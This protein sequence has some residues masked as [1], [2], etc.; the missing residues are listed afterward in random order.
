MTCGSNS[1]LDGPRL[2]T[3][4]G[5]KS[6]ESN[7]ASGVIGAFAASLVGKFVGEISGAGT[8]GMVGVVDG[9]AG[10]VGAVCAPGTLK[11]ENISFVAGNDGAPE[12]GAILAPS[13]K[14]A[15]TPGTA[16]GFAVEYAGARRGVTSLN[17]AGIALNSASFK[18]GAGVDKFGT[19]EMDGVPGTVGKEIS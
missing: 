1:R 6:N 8:G 2:G 16:G 13:R 5:R 19:A 17:V 11:N 9:T 4:S 10:I 12:N 15:L 14:Y 18:E 3:S 7:F